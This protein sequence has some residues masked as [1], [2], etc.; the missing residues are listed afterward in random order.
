MDGL[1]DAQVKEFQTDD[2]E[3]C[4]DFDPIAQIYTDIW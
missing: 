2:Y 1:I 4:C 3:D